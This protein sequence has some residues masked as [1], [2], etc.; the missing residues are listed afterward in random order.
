MATLG[1]LATLGDIPFGLDTGAY[2]SNFLNAL[3]LAVPYYAPD[4]STWLTSD[5]SAARQFHQPAVGFENFG[6]TQCGPS[7]SDRVGSSLI[8]VRQRNVDLF[9]AVVKP[10][11][12]TGSMSQFIVDLGALEEAQGFPGIMLSQDDAAGHAVF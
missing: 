4:I 7:A 2:G 3:M 8:D 12:Q 5:N 9:P 1:S 6:K 11:E 10:I